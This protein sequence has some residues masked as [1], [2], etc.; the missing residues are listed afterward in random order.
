M[1]RRFKRIGR[2]CHVRHSEE[3]VRAV[4]GVVMKLDRD[5]VLAIVKSRK[6]RRSGDLEVFRCRVAVRYIGAE[7]AVAGTSGF[8]E[9]LCLDA[10]DIED[11]GVVRGN[12]AGNLCHGGGV[13]YRH[14]CAEIEG[15]I[16]VLVVG[17]AVELGC[18]ACVQRAVFCAE[19]TGSRGP[20]AVVKTGGRP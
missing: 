17:A 14:L 2:A 15:G 20:F 10:V 6:H 19:R 3:D 5:G 8:V 7:A 18:G 13:L 16:I 4:S 9:A 1:G 12:A 11:D